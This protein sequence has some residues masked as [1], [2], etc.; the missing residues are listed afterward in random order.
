MFSSNCI[1]CKIIQKQIPSTIIKE[2][3]D[4]MVIKDLYPKSPYH[5]LIIP[6]KHIEN[7]CVIKDEELFILSKMGQVARDLSIE[8]A[9]QNNQSEPVAFNLVSNNGANAGQS[10]FHMHWHFLAG[11]NIYKDGLKL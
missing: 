10:V 6:K 1:F 2:T 11:K 7:L 5:Y 9:A 8:I 4:L 3:E